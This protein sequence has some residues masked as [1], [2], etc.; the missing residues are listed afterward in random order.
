M[1]LY[2][3]VA[4]NKGY[5]WQTDGGEVGDGQV[6]DKLGSR[7]SLS[8][9]YRAINRFSVDMDAQYVTENSNYADTSTRQ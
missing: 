4:M 7:A 5:C 6:R 8:K 3:M 9:I 1:L 2:P